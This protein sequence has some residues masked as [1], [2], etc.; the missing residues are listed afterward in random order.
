MREPREGYTA[1]GRVLRPHGIRGELRVAAF[2]SSGVNL[3]PGRRVWIGERTFRIRRARRDRDA[4]LLA[5]EGLTTRTEAESVRGALLEVPDE[6]LQRD[7]EDSF[8]VF[9]LVG[10]DVLT[11]EGERLGEV[12][13]VLATG[14]NDVFVVRHGERELL[15]PAIGDVVRQVDLE[16]RRIV[17]TPLPGL[18]DDPA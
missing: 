1:V 5:L 3:Q 17:I 10:L 8:F 16:A 4:W 11:D 14:A 15:V 18:L 13:D 2:H 6:E 12:V 7:D 9:E